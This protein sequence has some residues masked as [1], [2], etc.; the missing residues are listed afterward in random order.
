MLLLNLLLFPWFKLEVKVVVLK[1][2]LSST[3]TCR[4]CSWSW[5]LVSKMR[6]SKLLDIAGKFT[7]LWTLS[8]VKIGKKFQRQFPT[9]SSCDRWTGGNN[10]MR[11]TGMRRYQSYLLIHFAVKCVSKKKATDSSL[12]LTRCIAFIFHICNGYPVKIIN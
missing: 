1:P 7:C 6:I 4:P 5:S 3:S 8:S 2:R 9:F 11:F 12:H 10:W